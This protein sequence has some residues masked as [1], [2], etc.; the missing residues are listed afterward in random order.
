MRLNRNPGHDSSKSETCTNNIQHRLTIIQSTKPADMIMTIQDDLPTG[1]TVA[2]SQEQTH[3]LSQMGVL[4]T[5]ETAPAMPCVAHTELYSKAASL[6]L[7]PQMQL[8]QELPKNPCFPYFF[9]SPK[10]ERQ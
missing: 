2:H 7:D 5:P 8:Y 4:V 10:T 6:D 9:S 1:G 3:R